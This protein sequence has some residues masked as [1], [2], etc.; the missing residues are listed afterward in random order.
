MGLI[1][2]GLNLEFT[3]FHLWDGSDYVFILV[4]FSFFCAKHSPVLLRERLC[5]MNKEKVAV[6]TS[7]F[8][9]YI[10]VSY[11]KG[12]TVAAARDNNLR[13]LGRSMN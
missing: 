13:K 4:I 1:R 5:H 2:T 3:L 12:F 6:C 11:S 7:I 9:L 8:A 10:S